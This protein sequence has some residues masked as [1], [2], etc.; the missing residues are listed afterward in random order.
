PDAPAG[1]QPRTGADADRQG[2][3][4]RPNRR[5]GRRRGR[6]SCQAVRHRR[7]QGA[8]QGTAAPSAR[9]L[10]AR[11]RPVVRRAP[12]RSRPP[13]RRAGRAIRRVDPDR[14]PAAGADDAQPATGAAAFGHLRPR[15][16]VRLRAELQRP[17]CLYR[18]PSAQ[19]RGRRRAAGDPH[20][21]GR[22]IRAAG[23]PGM[24]LRARLGLAAGIAVAVA[25]IAVVVSAYEGTRSDLQGQL[26]NS[27]THLA[28]PVL[29]RAAGPPGVL[30]PGPAS[31]GGGQP[32]AP[33]SGQGD[34]D[35]GLGLDRQGP[36]AFGGPSG[37]FTLVYP[38]GVTYSPPSQTYRIPADARAKSLAR[39]GNGRYFTDM[40]V[41]KTHIR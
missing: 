3:R 19:A 35:E 6:L 18:L 38:S 29:V 39:S 11:R 28:Q 22:R 9:R 20:R 30:T 25:V 32:A 7:A 5:S 10:G 24:T 36:E 40:T 37:T 2:R 15:V 8:A 1:R 41:S 27:I 16:G 23:A 21:P 13:R 12:T 33:R 4:V 26:D 14:V 31:P 17:A 34:P